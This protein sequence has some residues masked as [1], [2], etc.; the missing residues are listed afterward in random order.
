MRCPKCNY[1]SFDEMEICGG[2]KKNIS[3]YS[4]ALHGVIFK[5]DT[6][7]FLWLQKPEPEE[8]LEEEVETAEEEL[9]E[10][11][12][13]PEEDDAGLDM[14]LEADETVEFAAD[15]ADEMELDLD[16]PA[17]DEEPQEIEFDLEGDAADS[18]GQEEPQMELELPQEDEAPE[19][20]FS[21]DS[22]EAEAD[23]SELP[24]LSMD[25][26]DDLDMQLD[27][28]DAS[29]SVSLEKEKAAAPKK[30]P[31]KKE[32]AAAAPEPSFNLDEFDLSGLM[33]PSAGQDETIEEL[34][35][36]SLES[37]DTGK[38]RKKDK[39]AEGE[40]GFDLLS[41]L[42]VDGLDLD[43]PIL[44]PA[45]SAAGKKMRPA[46]K[47]GTALDSFDIDLGDLLGGSEKK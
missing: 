19:L 2:C 15:T 29:S 38:G 22:G 41:D 8:A 14:G 17:A 31:P 7:D 36:L 28:D 1:I 4:Q 9:E 3:K 27:L 35:E 5:A 47:T 23:Q 33:P 16:S 39:K 21:L 30:S 18:G 11:I 34:G 32:K 10:E 20:D 24:E 37:A 6:P 26:L 12:A 45:S 46:A 13:G 44:P 43:A 40:Q 42:S 25:G